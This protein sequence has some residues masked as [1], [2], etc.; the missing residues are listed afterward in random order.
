MT[1]MRVAKTG[2]IVMSVV[3][4]VVGVLFIALPARSAVMIGRV[5]GAAMA[6]F[7]VVKLV[8][9]FSRDLY[10]LAFQY[11]LEFGILLI[12]LGVIVL[13][14]TN[15]VMDFICIAAGVAILADGLFKIQIAIDS[16]RFGIRDW[17]LIMVLAVVTGGVGLLLIFRPWESVQVLTVLLGA[18]LLAEGVLNLCVALSAVKIV[19]NQQPDVIETDYFEVREYQ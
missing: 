16:R 8:G 10:R 6:V 18:A 9:Y 14:R 1:P 2:Y 17:W 3:F 4:C 5:L 13:L 7:G 12:A 19:K 11:D 15:G